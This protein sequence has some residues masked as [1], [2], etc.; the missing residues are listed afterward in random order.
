MDSKIAKT[1]SC[2]GVGIPSS[3]IAAS[4]PDVMRDLDFE[5]VERLFNEDCDDEG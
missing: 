1:P 2:I 3:A 5:E 4:F